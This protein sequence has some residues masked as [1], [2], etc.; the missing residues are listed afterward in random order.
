VLGLLANRTQS[1]IGPITF[2]ALFNFSSFIALYYG[3]LSS[4]P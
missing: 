4:A 3:A 2:H 1:L